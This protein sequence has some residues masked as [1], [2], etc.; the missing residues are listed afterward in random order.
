LRASKN[1]APVPILPTFA[2]NRGAGP[3]PA[4]ASHSGRLSGER[5]SL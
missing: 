3:R 4:A 2:H 1:S 5:S